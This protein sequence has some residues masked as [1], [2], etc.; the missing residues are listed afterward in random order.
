MIHDIASPLSA[1]SG[2]IKLLREEDSRGA[3]RR[4]ILDHACEAINQI[5]KIIE[6]SKNLMQGKKTVIQFNPK[7]KIINL[8]YILRNKIDNNNINVKLDLSNN[9]KINGMVTLFE[10]IIMNVLQNAIE[11]L[12]SL[13]RNST[14][15]RHRKIE[16]KD[17]QENDFYYLYVKDNGEG[18]SESNL[19][20]IFTPGFTLKSKNH[21]GLGLSFVKQ[22]IEEYFGGSVEVESVPGSF[23]QVTLKFRI[24]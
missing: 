9:F 17:L 14:L 8:L 6:N 23:T 1:L 7:D 24:R 21:F 13:D 4:E 20:K 3:E 10:R 19:S 12:I 16:I 11:E 15:K 5:D 22:Y 18:I 2:A